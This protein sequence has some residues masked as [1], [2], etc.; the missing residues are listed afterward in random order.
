MSRKMIDY[1]VKGDKISSIDGYKVGSTLVAGDN[2]IKLTD[3][4]T[5]ETAI[6]AKSLLKY[7]EYRKRITITAG[8]YHSGDIIA[9]S[10]TIPF[11]EGYKGA[12]F[13]GCRSGNN[14]IEKITGTNMLVYKQIL[15]F[16]SSPTQYISAK[17]IVLN[18][19]TIADD[20]VYDFGF[21]YTILTSI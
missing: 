20:T 10:D 7:K 14:I 5:G 11:D 18:D 21:D 2:S 13:V 8:T 6:T 12:L 16:G 17:L 1:Q 4:E 19:I 9:I 15:M 3:K